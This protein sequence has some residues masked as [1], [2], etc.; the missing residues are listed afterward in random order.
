M[1]IDG[2][3]RV[4]LE[5][6]VRVFI[7]ANLAQACHLR[8][9]LQSRQDSAMEGA[10]LYQVLHDLDRRIIEAQNTVSTY[11]RTLAEIDQ[12]Q[13]SDEVQKQLLSV[14]ARDPVSA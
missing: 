7:G 2:K 10:P 8:A 14:T 13:R 4:V 11:A 12:Q 9:V 5:S 1:Q 3:D 6:D